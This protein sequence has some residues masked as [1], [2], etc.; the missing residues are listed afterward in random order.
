MIVRYGLYEGQVEV[1]RKNEFD[2]HFEN[3]VI[4][5]LATMPGVVGVRLLRG[6]QV[7]DVQPRFHHVIELTFL[8]QEGLLTAMQSEQR[9]AIQAAPWGVMEFFEGAT[10]HANLTVAITLDGPAAL[11]VGQGHE[12]G[13]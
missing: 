9:R 6:I 7:G 3:F 11:S 8:D 4:P 13:R 2:A 5:A 1:E 12:S 10:P